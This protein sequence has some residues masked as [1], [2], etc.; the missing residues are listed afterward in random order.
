[1]KFT[2]ADA[3]RYWWPVPVKIPHPTTAGAIETQTLKIQFEPQG[4]DQALE[5]LERYE[6]LT[7]L[8]ARA[9]HERDQLM[10]VV[11]NWDDVVDDEGGAIGFSEEM[12]RKALQ[13]SWFR[14]AVFE[15]YNQSLLG[16][17][18]RLGN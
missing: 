11:R 18:A 4:Q 14:S 12:L 2:L 13:A 10:A 16:Q 15:A 8:R 3:H 6:G 17:E 5:A 7:S 1:M 9:E